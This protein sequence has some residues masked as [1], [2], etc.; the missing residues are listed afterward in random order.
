MAYSNN[1]GAFTPN[2]M[3]EFHL[4]T[5][6]PYICKAIDRFTFCKDKLILICEFVCKESLVYYPVPSKV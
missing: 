1:Y 4:A 6:L 5:L 3:F 2:N